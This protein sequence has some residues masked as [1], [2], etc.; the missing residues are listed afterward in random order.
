MNIRLVSIAAC[1][2]VSGCVKAQPAPAQSYYQP[3]WVDDVFAHKAR[4]GDGPME[5][6]ATLDSQSERTACVAPILDH[7]LTDERSREAKQGS[8]VRRLSIT[9]CQRVTLSATANA[10]PSPY[11]LGPNWRSGE[12][13]K[14]LTPQENYCIAEARSHISP[15]NNRFPGMLPEGVT[16]TP[17]GNGGWW[18]H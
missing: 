6:C 10:N 9:Q 3:P 8:T 2:L 12:Y 17:L 18:L 15:A 11:A 7:A 4:P 5:M 13:N 14:Y 16:A 1:V